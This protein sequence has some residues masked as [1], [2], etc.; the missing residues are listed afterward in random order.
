MGAFQ[1]K[2]VQLVKAQDG[3]ASASHE[4]LARD[5]VRNAM[6]DLY[7]AAGGSLEDLAS[8]ARQ[9]FGESS[10]ETRVDTAMGELLQALAV[11]GHIHDMDIIQAGYNTLDAQIRDLKHQH[12]LLVD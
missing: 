2:A 9:R 6:I 11:L 3:D 1:N 10:D 5:R 8:A 12:H 7:R 4:P